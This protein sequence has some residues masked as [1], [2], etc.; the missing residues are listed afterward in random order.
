MA[1]HGHFITIEGGEGVGKSLFLRGLASALTQAGCCVVATREPGGTPVAQSLRKIF[2]QPADG[3]TLTMITELFLVNACRSQH[4]THLVEP[5]LSRGEWVIS[6]RFAD[7][8]RI[9]QGMIGGVDRNLV[10]LTISAATGGRQPDLTF[11]LDCD[12]D[13]AHSRRMDRSGDGVV[14]Y[15][16]AHESVHQRMRECF[17]RLAEEFPRRVVV[18]DA[19]GEPEA[20]LHSAWE[21]LRERFP[22][23]LGAMVEPRTTPVGAK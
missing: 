2:A 21:V 19:S 3:E 17:L 13:V 6:D 11:V 5:A 23:A 15:D 10:E 9:Y 4:V 18:L 12:V 20:V 1:R 8:T 16:D 7:S 14:R 22:E